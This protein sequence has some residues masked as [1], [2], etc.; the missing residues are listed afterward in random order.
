MFT[1]LST[2]SN[3]GN[4]LEILS[5]ANALIEKHAGIITKQSHVY[6]TAAWG[7]TDQPDFYN[8]ALAVETPFSPILLFRKL[9]HIE[10]QLGRKRIE[11]WGPRIIDIDIIFFDQYNLKNDLLTIPH[12]E[13]QN[14]NFVLFPLTEIA[15]K[16]VHPSL[17]ISLETLARKSD[18]PLKAEKIYVY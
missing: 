11:K 3:Q 14:R 16:F 1:L 2:G 17:K 15:P 5:K 13:M 12:P 8:Q 6:K 7:K 18:D 4:S 9:Q 10:Q